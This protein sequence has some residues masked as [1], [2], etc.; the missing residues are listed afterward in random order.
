ML[1][2]TSTLV[3][4]HLFAAEDHQYPAFRIELDDHVRPLVGDPY[5][6][7]L[8]DLDNVS[9]APCVQMVPD[10]TDVLSVSIKLEQL[11]RSRAIGGASCAATRETKTCPLELTATP[12][13]SPNK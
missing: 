4:A 1:E 10:F 12:A 2:R 3:G 11:S 8:V 13:A 6:V 7:S 5:V 9:K